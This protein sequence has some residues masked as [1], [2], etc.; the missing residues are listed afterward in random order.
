MNTKRISLALATLALLSTGSAYAQYVG[1]N[2]CSNQCDG[3]PIIYRN[4]NRDGF[5]NRRNGLFDLSFFGLGFG[6][7]RN[8]VIDNCGRQSAYGSNIYRTNEF[9]RTIPGGLTPGCAQPLGADVQSR[10]RLFFLDVFSA[11][12]LRFGPGIPLRADMRID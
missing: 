6:G 11:R 8:N 1:G 12:L 7:R 9:A 3:T 10:K 5:L 2:A 4:S